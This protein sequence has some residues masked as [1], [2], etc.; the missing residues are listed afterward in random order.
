M[1]SDRFNVLIVEDDESVALAMADVL[2][3][4]G[5]K[6]WTC[7]SSV[8]A[9]SEL[10]NQQF[11]CIILDM[12]LK[13]GNGEQVISF[14]HLNQTFSNLKVPILVISG[15][16]DSELV[17]NL[18]GRIAGALVKPFNPADLTERVRTLINTPPID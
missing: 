5:F 14:L 3:R 17:K 6:V 4:D 12:R 7:D 13:R 9:I 16:L 2:K 18:K 1:S 11:H 8:E 15:F 10:K